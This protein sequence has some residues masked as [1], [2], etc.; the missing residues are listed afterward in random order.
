[1]D[2]D[3]F[4][5]DHDTDSGHHGSWRRQIAVVS[6]EDPITTAI[7]AL[8]EHYEAFEDAPDDIELE[9]T[10]EYDD[11][12]EDELRA[13]VNKW[14]YDTCWPWVVVGTD[15]TEESCCLM[16]S[17]SSIREVMYG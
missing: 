9:F 15:K 16:L 8:R 3:T 12:D 4:S 5:E 11:Y 2:S 14:L 17:L 1:M 10:F 6:S 7:E 13:Q